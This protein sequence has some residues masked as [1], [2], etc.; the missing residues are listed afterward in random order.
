MELSTLYVLDFSTAQV[1]K[2]AIEADQQIEDVEEFINEQG[3][4]VKDCEF[5][6]GDSIK[7][8][9]HVAEQKGGEFFVDPYA[10]NEEGYT[11]EDITNALKSA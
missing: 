6:Y 3:H 2:Y 7:L 1:H 5:M 10:E 9:D 8:V 11:D 4:R